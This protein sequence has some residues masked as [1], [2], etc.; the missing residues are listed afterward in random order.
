MIDHNL[1]HGCLACTVLDVTEAVVCLP[2]APD[3]EAFADDNDTTAGLADFGAHMFGERFQVVT[4]L[5]EIELQGHLPVRIRQ[6]RSRRYESGGSAHCL[7]DGYRLGHTH[8]A[9]L[10]LDILNYGSPVPR[11]TAITGGV[12]Y[13]PEVF[14]ADIVVDRL[15]HSRD[16]EIVS[17]FGRQIGNLLG[18]VHGV[19][20][21]DVEEVADLMSLH[22]IED[23]LIVR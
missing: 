12:I 23:S 18:G 16:Y 11:S 1:S 6:P 17:L 19:V 22:H 7:Q 14:V 13:Y 5:R 21:A 2:E 8:A 3:V 20:P 10:F 15:W 4:G 9:V